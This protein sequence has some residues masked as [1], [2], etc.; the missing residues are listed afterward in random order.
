MSDTAK[1]IKRLEN[2]ADAGWKILPTSS[3]EMMNRY[4]IWKQIQE[5][6]YELGDKDVLLRLLID[7]EHL[8]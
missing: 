2:K 1:L 6:I 5:I 7:N 8:I 3:K 4:M